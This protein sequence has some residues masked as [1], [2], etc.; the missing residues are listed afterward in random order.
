MRS[1]LWYVFVFIYTVVLL[2]S[3]IIIQDPLWSKFAFFA[4]LAPVMVSSFRSGKNSL[5]AES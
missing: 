5:E 2:A 3:T 1:M 4:L